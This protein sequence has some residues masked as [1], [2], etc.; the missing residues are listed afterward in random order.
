MA[1]VAILTVF[2]RASRGDFADMGGPAAEDWLRTTI[3]PPVEILR[4]VA[5]TGGG[6]G[7]PVAAG[8]GGARGG[9]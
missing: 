7:D 4:R 8:G 1:R 2:N 6:D 5:G 3:L 9:R